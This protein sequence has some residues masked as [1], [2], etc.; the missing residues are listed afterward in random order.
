MSMTDPVADM[1][2]RLRNGINRKKECVDI[3]A[4]KLKEGVCRKLFDQGYIRDVKSIGNKRQGILRVYLKYDDEG[5]SLISALE[6]KSK[7]SLRVYLGVDEIPIVKS[8]LGIAMLSTPRGVLTG[9]EA[10]DQNVGGEFLCEV[11]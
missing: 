6:R 5:K 2:T 1:L 10:R 8:G 9:K 11:W 4:S 3:P 7:P